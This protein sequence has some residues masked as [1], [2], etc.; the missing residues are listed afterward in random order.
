VDPPFRRDLVSETDATFQLD[1]ELTPELRRELTSLWLDVGRAGGAVGVP[2]EPTLTDVEY[3][4]STAFGRLASAGDHLMVAFVDGS[5]AG[6]AFLEQRS[7][8][9]FRHWATVKRLQVHPRLQGRG[10]GRALL[11]ATHDAA[12]RLGYEQL[13]LTVRGGTGTERLYE[14]FGY[15]VVAV[16]PGAIRVAPGDDRDELYMIARL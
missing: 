15:E 8:E 16:I 1:P 10:L 12:R 7:G 14:Q 4:A 13:H 9:L 2:V 3:M 5:P 11:S 6:M